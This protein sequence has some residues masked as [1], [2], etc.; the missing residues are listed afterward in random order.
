MKGA[1]GNTR[2]EMH[3]GMKRRKECMEGKL[4]GE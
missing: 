4:K 2:I 3:K 1:E